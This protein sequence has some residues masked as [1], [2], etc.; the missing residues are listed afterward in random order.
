[1]NKFVN[2]NI[3]TIIVFV[4]L[5]IKDFKIIGKTISQLLDILKYLI[6]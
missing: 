1:M 5:Y 4:N 6:L 3:S 2:I